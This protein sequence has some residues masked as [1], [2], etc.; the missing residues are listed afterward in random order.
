[1]IR[2]QMEVL[3]KG[4][5]QQKEKIEREVNFKSTLNTTQQQI[6]D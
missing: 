5:A 2:P 1:M 6:N 3:A 4:L